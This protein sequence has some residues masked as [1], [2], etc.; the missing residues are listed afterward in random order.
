[1]KPLQ[2]RRKPKNQSTLAPKAPQNE[3]PPTHFGT[4]P[5]YTKLRLMWIASPERGDELTNLSLLLSSP[6]VSWPPQLEPT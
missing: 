4:V 6:I 5:P 3:P 1:M 2:N